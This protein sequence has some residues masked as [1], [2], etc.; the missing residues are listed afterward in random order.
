MIEMN[1]LAVLVAAIIPLVVGAIYYNPKVLG[2]AWMNASGMTEE[3][4]QGGNM[5]K[6]FGLTLLFSL[7][8]ASSI[9]PAVIH[10]MNVYSLFAN[11][12]T[13]MDPGSET[14]AYLADFM[15]KY[16][17]N[18]RTFKHGAFHG[19]LMSLFLALPILGINSL[20]ERRS[21]KYIFIHLGYWAITLTLM[22]AIISGWK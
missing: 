18:F 5:V 7:M 4:I 14:G 2:N 13:A 17:D 1:W 16:G 6:I 11:D 21:A 9:M 15:A 3:M 19:F 22:G 12:P 8:L 10:Q 20:F